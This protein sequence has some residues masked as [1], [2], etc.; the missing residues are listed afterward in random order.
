VDLLIRELTVVVGDANDAVSADACDT[1]RSPF[2]IWSASPIQHDIGECNVVV[3]PLPSAKGRNSL[4]ELL[5][6]SHSLWQTALESLKL[7][8]PEFWESV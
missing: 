2:E 4:V 6:A 1:G 3:G 7:N 8:G 5:L